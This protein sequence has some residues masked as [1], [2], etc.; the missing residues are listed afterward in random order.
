MSP[1]GP[2]IEKDRPTLASV[3]APRKSQ[4]GESLGDVSLDSATFGRDPNGA[5]LH[6]VVKAQLAARRAGTQST[7]DRE[8]VRGGGRKP[9]R[10]KGTGNARQGSTRSPLWPGGG[11]ALGPKPR[12]Y[13]QRTPKKM[14]RLALVSALSARA[15]DGAIVVVDEFAPEEGKTKAAAQT[16]AALGLFGTVLAVLPADAELARR[17]LR[18][19]PHVTVVAPADL[20]AYE[21]LRVDWVLFTDASLPGAA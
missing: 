21:V 2:P 9:F 17:A 18:N 3:S 6:Q 19:L 11:V 12:S 16:L 8:E 1:V 14:V 13:A 4:G 15:A 20:T 7:K 5:V 10:Q